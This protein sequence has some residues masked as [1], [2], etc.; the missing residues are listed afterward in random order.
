MS[1]NL[2]QL[3]DDRTLARRYRIVDGQLLVLGVAGILAGLPLS[4]LGGN[5]ALQHGG[6]TSGLW[7]LYGAGLVVIGQGLARRQSIWRLPAALAVLPGLLSWSPLG[8]PL[9]V[10]VLWVL[11][12]DEA[13]LVLTDD[14]A[15]ARSEGLTPRPALWLAFALAGAAMSQPWPT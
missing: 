7:A 12:T 11:S 3:A 5:H 10:F 15:Q 4:I 6:I 9:S 1:A 14:Y 2:Q 13:E 8:L